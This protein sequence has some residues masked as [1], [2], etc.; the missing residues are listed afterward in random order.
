MATARERSSK[1]TPGMLTVTEVAHLLH[2]HPNTVR[3]WSDKG[4]IRSYRV[5]YRRDR[6]FKADDIERF[7]AGNGGGEAIPLEM[8]Q[9]GDI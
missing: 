2:V 5:G 7:L 6:R 8:A 3:I 4:L 9:E 1:S